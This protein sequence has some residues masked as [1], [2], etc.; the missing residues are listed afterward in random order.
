MFQNQ[1]IFHNNQNKIL[2]SQQIIAKS[3]IHLTIQSWPQSNLCFSGQV[4]HGI[5]RVF[6]SSNLCHLLSIHF[7]SPSPVLIQSHQLSFEL[8][9][10]LQRQEKPN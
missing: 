1:V 6:G 9:L 4:V 7:A 2:L 3:I 5:P 10:R 8:D